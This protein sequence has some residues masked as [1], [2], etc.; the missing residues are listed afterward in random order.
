MQ[1][2]SS[3][4]RKNNLLIETTGNKGGNRNKIFIDKTFHNENKEKHIYQISA[5]QLLS[6]FELCFYY[7]L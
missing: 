6:N 2:T 5:I 4:I 1:A 7:F 3:I